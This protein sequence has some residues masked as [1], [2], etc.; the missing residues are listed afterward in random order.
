[1]SAAV[2]IHGI[3]AG[4]EGVGTLPDGRTV[5]VPRTA[6]GDTVTLRA[7]R[8]SRRFARARL[9]EVL[10]PSPQRVAPQCPHYEADDCGGCQL[11]HLDPDSQRGAR[12]RLVGDA[13]RRIG[14]LNVP[15]PDL[16]PS[17]REWEYRSRITLA[18]EQCGRPA[19]R[20]RIGFHPLDRPERVFDLTRCPIAR[21]ELNAL[22]SGI[23][24]RRDLLPGNAERVVL[25]VDRDGGC[26]AIVKTVGTRT[27][28]RAGTLGR[29]LRDRDLPATL[30]W[31]PRGGAPRVLF[32]GDDPYPATVFEQVHPVMGDRVRTYA[33]G[34]LGD[35]QGSHVWDLYAGIG[36]ATALMLQS[37]PDGRVPPTVESV[38]LDRRA[39]RLAEERGPAEGV[40]RHAGRAEEWITRL[41]P[42]DA[43][44]VNPPRTGLAETVTDRLASILPRRLVYVSC[45]PA[46]LARDLGRLGPAYRLIDLRCFDL[47]PQTAHVESVA[48][49]EPA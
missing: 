44:L 30:W 35:L 29:E 19:P 1:V 46:T 37:V 47:F 23:R 18:V 4:G 20:S 16:E 31:A 15:D 34:Q 7:I 6:P 2:S 27:W 45:D 42:C 22:W 26:H 48:T 11:Q 24:N 32:G 17:D 12:A 36:E 13:L 5:F 38:E 49:L 25:R 33:V 39:V 21:P 8:P 14:H 41:R 9:S 10:Q 43:A 28:A 40:T 3:A